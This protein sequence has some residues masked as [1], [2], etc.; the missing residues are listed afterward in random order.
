[1]EKADRD[2]ELK[3]KFSFIFNSSVVSC[4]GQW[5][6]VRPAVKSAVCAVLQVHAYI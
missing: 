1:M 5:F 4:G 6:S 3:F 2:D